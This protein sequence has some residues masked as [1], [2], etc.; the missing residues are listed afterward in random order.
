MEGLL[1]AVTLSIKLWTTKQYLFFASI[2]V[3]C[4]LETCS[5]GCHCPSSVVI[6]GSSDKGELDRPVSDRVELNSSH[7]ASSN[8][9]LVGKFS[10]QRESLTV[11][12][13]RV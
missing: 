11:L 5:G 3:N 13:S 6:D 2:T 10:Q 4:P 1:G 12:V 9:L 7:S 8:L